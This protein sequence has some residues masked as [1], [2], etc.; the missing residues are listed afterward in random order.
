MTSPPVATGA[1]TGG[2]P[3]SA[4]PADPSDAATIIA[5]YKKKFAVNE[6]DFDL[7]LAA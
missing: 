3:P 5:K 6:F 1:R 4:S 2:G 7:D